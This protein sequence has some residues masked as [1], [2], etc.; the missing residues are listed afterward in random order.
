MSDDVPDIDDIVTHDELPEFREELV[1]D[2]ADAVTDQIDFDPEVPADVPTFSDVDER[3]EMHAKALL[4]HLADEEC[5]DDQCQELRDFLGFGDDDGVEVDDDPDADP[6][7]DQ[8]PESSDQPDESDDPDDEPE[9]SG[10]DPSD[11]PDGGDEPW[12][13]DTNVFGEPV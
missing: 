10:D 4:K 2:V 1:D 7:D 6:D 5:D 11:D 12:G 13:E 9:S 8:E 3:A